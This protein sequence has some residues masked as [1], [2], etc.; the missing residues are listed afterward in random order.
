MRRELRLGVWLKP[1]AFM[2]PK[3][4]LNSFAATPPLPTIPVEF[5][6]HYLLH[7]L[8]MFDAPIPYEIMFERRPQYL[9]AR[10][11]AD[12]IDRDMALRYLRELADKCAEFHANRVML[13]RNVP[14]MLC[15]VDNYLIVQ[16]IGRIFGPMRCAVINPHVFND[17]TVAFGSLVGEN[18]NLPWRSFATVE[19]A[20]A[21]L[22]SKHLA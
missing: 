4:P 15:D 16:E 9:Y 3:R 20:E 2:I 22:L 21:W 12:S 1:C 8:R 5:L 18:R 7:L 17:D 14:A 6:P 13:E 11:T 10:I 19:E